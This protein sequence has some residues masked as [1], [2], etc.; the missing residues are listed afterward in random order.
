MTNET[1]M[2]WYNHLAV[3]F[4]GFFLANVFPHFISGATGQE[5]PSPFANPPGVGLSSPTVNVL[6]G[7]ANLVFSYVL[8]RASKARFND[9]KAM[10]SFFVGI[11]ICSL[12]LSTIFGANF[13]IG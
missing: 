12:L 9:S 2:K 5:F 10:F 1:T 11:A 3:I 6:W 4:A 13:N 7:L 8:L